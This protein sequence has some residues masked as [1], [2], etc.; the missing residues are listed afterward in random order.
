MSDD[1]RVCSFY[2][3]ERLEEALVKGRKNNKEQPSEDNYWLL[4]V[5]VEQ[6]LHELQ[7]N[8]GVDRIKEGRCG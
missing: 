3:C 1:Y 6:L 7:R 2:V 8:I 4:N 5:L